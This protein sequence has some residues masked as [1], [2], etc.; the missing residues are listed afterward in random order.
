MTDTTWFTDARFGLFVHWGLHS[1]AARHEWVQKHEAIP[2]EEYGRYLEYFDPDLFD[3]VAWAETAWQAGM[4]YTVITTKHHEGFCLWDSDLTDFKATSAP[5]GRDLLAEFTDAFRARG[6]KIGFYY[7]LIDWR[8]PEFPVDQYHPHSEDELAKAEPRDMGK[9]VEYMNGQVTELLTRYGQIDIIWFDYSYNRPGVWGGKGPDDWESENLLKLARDL[10]PGILVNNRLGIPGDFATP[11]Q[12][13]PS[14]PPTQDG[15]PIVWEACHTL[16]GSW[17][18]D[19]DNH[20]FKSPDLLARMLIDSVAKNGNVLL[21]VGPNGRGE[22]EPTAVERLS[23]L[24]GWMRLHERS[25]RGAGASDFQAP[26]DMRFTQRGNRL[27]L[28]LYTWP[29]KHVHLQDMAGKV[30][31]AQFLHDAS[32]VGLKW[33]GGAVHSQLEDSSITED[34][35]TLIVPEQKPDVLVPV[36]ELFLE[37]A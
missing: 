14:N 18:Y 5:A 27:Y 13:Q 30:A 6:F 8:H 36:I 9:Y 31:Y 32:E 33:H 25:I 16:N 17:G 26:T 10:Q 2:T 4:R 15:E 20:R 34:T 22:L 7:S 28:H 37:E 19:R 35:L 11:E 29:L 12:F 3:P 21:N 23:A 1:L 24:A